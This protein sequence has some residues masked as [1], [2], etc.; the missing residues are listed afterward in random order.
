MR[1]DSFAQSP[2]ARPYRFVWLDGCSTA[3]GD[4]PEAFGVNKAT[5]SLSYY[6]NAT[7]N[8]SRRR[9]S[10]F[11]GWI[12]KVGGPGWGTVQNAMNCRTEWMFD[13]QQNWTFRTLI[14]ALYNGRQNSNWVPLDQFRNNI[15]VYGYVELKMNEYNQKNDWPGP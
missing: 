11:V 2:H 6:T 9:P 7:T 13:W 12:A 15:R 8:P 1:M 4:W 3:K 5:Y 10:A 14:D